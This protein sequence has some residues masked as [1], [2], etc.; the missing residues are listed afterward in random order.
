MPFG[1]DNAATHD[2]P[3][4]SYYYLIDIIVKNG[5]IGILSTE[6]LRNSYN[7]IGIVRRVKLCC[8]CGW[9][10]ELLLR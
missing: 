9:L 3:R 10:G 8:L 4:H 7:G 5:L 2:Q 1:G 6:F